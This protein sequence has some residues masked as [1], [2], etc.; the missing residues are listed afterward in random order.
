VLGRDLA[1]ELFADAMA[2]MNRILPA[3]T[4]PEGDQ[5][6]PGRQSESSWAPSP[7]TTSTYDA[8]ND[9]NEL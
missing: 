2:L 3:P 8:A 7:L 6:R 9:N 1:P 5:A 4:T